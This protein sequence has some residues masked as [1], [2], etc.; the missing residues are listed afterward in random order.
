MPSMRPRWRPGVAP[1][2]ADPRVLRRQGWGRELRA[3]GH[4]VTRRLRWSAI[5]LVC[6][7]QVHLDVDVLLEPGHDVQPLRLTH[8]G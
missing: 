1:D 4:M 5:A 6:R 3:S 7:A 8:F 2:R